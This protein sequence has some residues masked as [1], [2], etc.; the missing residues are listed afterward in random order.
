MSRRREPK[1]VRDYIIG[2]WD[3]M[4]ELR[5][6]VGDTWLWPSHLDC[7]RYAFQELAEADDELM[8][9]SNNA[10][11]RRRDE[12]ENSFLDEMGMCVIML[13]SFFHE[14]DLHWQSNA[15][16]VTAGKDCAGRY[17]YDCAAYLSTDGDMP[18]I[19]WRLG[20]AWGNAAGNESTI[21]GYSCSNNVAA[22]LVKIHN[23]LGKRNM[24][25]GTRAAMKKVRS[26]VQEKKSLKYKYLKDGAVGCPHC[27]SDDLDT[28]DTNTDEAYHNRRIKCSKC[29]KEWLDVYK[30]VDVEL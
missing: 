14:D 15:T 10:H 12:T 9:V 18:E 30:L 16:V 22:C 19:A 21:T 23:M 25:K 5:H 27:G 24:T 3:E 7:I 11:L 29:K 1:V 8:R 6:E 26:R 20:S 13:L 17:I 2:L 28:M 4:V